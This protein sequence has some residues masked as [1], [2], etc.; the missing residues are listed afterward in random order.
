MQAMLQHF[1]PPLQLALVPALLIVTILC[2]AVLHGVVEKPARDRMRAYLRRLNP[3]SMQSASPP[4]PSDRST[5][6]WEG[7]GAN[8]V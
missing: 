5:A 8:A 4:L 2:A 6:G 1:S 7:G 3:A